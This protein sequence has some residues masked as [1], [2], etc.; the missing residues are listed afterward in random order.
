MVKCKYCGE[1]NLTEN[2]FCARCGQELPEGE[3]SEAKDNANK[4]QKSF[5]K[6]SLATLERSRITYV[7]TVCANINSIEQD[8]CG[9]CGKPRPRSEYVAALRKLKQSGRVQPEKPVAEPMP[10]LPAEEPKIE[11][12]VQQQ[13]VAAPASAGGQMPALQ[14]PFIVVP[15]VN[16]Q[17]PLW[18][19][20][21][22]QVY[23]FQPYTQEEIEYMREQQGQQAEPIVNE[24]PASDGKKRVRITSLLTLIVSIVML[25]C[26]YLVPYTNAAHKDPGI[27]YMAGIVSCLAGTGAAVT[28]K[29]L[30][31]TYLGWQSFLPPIFLMI[32]AALVIALVIRCVA[33]L[34]TGRAIVKGFVLPLFILLFFIASGI[35][36]IEQV[37]GLANGGFGTYFADA[38]AGTYLFI[39]LSIIL[40]VIALF[41]KAN[42]PSRKERKRMAAQADEE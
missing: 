12:A 25:I 35:V 11:E 9:T 5:D 2:K 39:V 36:I 27:F 18:Q 37:C 6:D 7:C 16:P 40:L 15:Y 14:Q 26:L 3:A 34:V 31:Y 19:Y 29:T 24:Q 1:M 30:P 23:R 28:E 22:N 33:R 21:P 4:A 10:Q 8:R 42:Y 20:K 32:A 38:A 13:P 17:Q 41:N